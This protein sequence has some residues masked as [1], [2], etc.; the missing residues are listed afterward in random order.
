MGFRTFG[1]PDAAEENLVSAH[2]LAEQYGYN[3]LLFQVESL[4][5]E[6]KRGETTRP[7]PVRETPAELRHVADAVSEMRQLVGV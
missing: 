2:E 3:Q 5:D 4:T 7:L 6:M 1:Q